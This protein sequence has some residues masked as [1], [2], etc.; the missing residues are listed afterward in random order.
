MADGCEDLVFDWNDAGTD[1]P[2]VHPQ[3]S[4]LDETLRDG[5]QSPSATD[6]DVADKLDL[7][8]RMDA[9]EID[10]FAAGIPASGARAFAD[11]LRIVQEVARQRLRIC[12]IAS[13]RTLPCDV[14][15]IVE[16]S[17]RA[18]VAVETY[19]F[20]GSS[21]IRQTVE[22]WDARQVADRCTSAI[23]MAVRA[24][25]PTTFVTEDTTRSHPDVLARLFRA[26]IDHGVR[27]IC[28]CDTAGHAGP[29]GVVALAKFARG[30]VADSGATVG[31][32]WHGHNDRGLALSN[33]LCAA[34]CGIDRIHGTALGIGERV[35]N[36]PM[37]LLLLN[38]RL[39]DERSRARLGT[40]LVEYC[41]AVARALKWPVAPNTPIVGRDAFR[42][43][44]GV[45]A[46]AVAKAMA[47]GRENLADR[48]YSSVPASSFGRSQEIAIGF[49]S[50]TSNVEFWLRSR[51][52]EPTEG[53]V[54][55]I[56]RAAKSSA[57]VLD[58][59]EVMDIVRKGQDTQH[60]R[61]G[62]EDESDAD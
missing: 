33:S 42:T 28:L 59:V 30:V 47:T 46:A 36:A 22:A 56:L 40:R 45:H 2:S 58:D 14:E 62:P 27:R 41:Q 18:G 60:L 7:V 12:P 51:G 55:A 4:L 44:A 52:F 31:L 53:R 21:S 29:T 38:L 39:R 19:V 32:D 20:I 3:L 43:A 16:I 24:G 11:V 9:L 6:P 57:R 50:G 49:M 54:A 8:H 23:D 34:E 37:E 5:L 15:P 48:V 61:K 26:A 25:L 1:R 17:Q 10:A 35:G 13:G